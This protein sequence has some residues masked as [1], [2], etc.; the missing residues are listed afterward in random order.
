MSTT[1][2]LG[3]PGTGKTYTLINIVKDALQNGVPPER[4]GFV[5]FSK[6]ATEE[7]RTR[8][9]RELNLDYKKMVHFRTLHSMAFRQLDM[10]I[11][12]VLRSSDYRRLEM[13]LGLP[14]TSTQSMNINDGEFF[15]LG[16]KGDMYLS[17][18]NMA[19]VRKI[20]AEQQFNES[21]NWTL[22]HNEM[23][24]VIRS[25][26]EYKQV[27]EKIDFVD[28]I[29]TFIEQGEAPEL[30]LLIVDEAQDLVPLQWDMVSKLESNSKNV[31]YAGDDDQAI[32]EW[33]GVDAR[34]FASRCNQSDKMIVLDQ[35]FRVPSS[36]HQ[37][38]DRIIRNAA[39]RIDK[40]WNAREQEGHV[41][42]HYKIDELPLEEGQW[43]IL[44]RTNY[45]AN[46]IATDLKN[47]G[48]LFWRNGNG[49]SIANAT[50]EVVR[51]FTRLS[52]GEELDH[53]YISKIWR[54]IKVDRKTRNAGNKMLKAAEAETFGIEFLESL[55]GQYL[56][57][58]HWYEVLEVSDQERV[59]I[60]SVLESG[61]VL[62]D[63]N[64]RIILSTIHKAKGGEADNVALVLES[65]KACCTMS[66]P[67]AE[68]R[69]FYVGA[70]RAKNN[71][72]I[73]DNPEARWRF[74]L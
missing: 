18:Y 50:L 70:T 52:R 41:S 51:G 58:K 7:A 38:A 72:Y 13:E 42:Y 53:E 6:K 40:E 65:T 11:D 71:L 62:N 69:V 55:T 10:K 31:Y 14:F 20:S 15:R 67:D 4:I 33:M 48:Y 25:Y 74:Q 73:I 43:M 22:Q 26:K 28:M 32:Y 12:Q 57:E 27:L 39:G 3:P 16:G 9:A 68:R 60:T 54:K 61:E 46:R 35:S 5:S 59:Y 45:I 47:N 8:A 1:A 56:Q 17:I 63:D 64:P 36:V 30:E 2:Y 19:R 34:Q 29:E 49:W 23:Q 37:E 44:A 21:A 24:H 66:E